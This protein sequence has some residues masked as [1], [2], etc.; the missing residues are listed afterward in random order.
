MKISKIKPREPSLKFF[1]EEDGKIEIVPQD[2]N[3][4]HRLAQFLL[5]RFVK[6]FF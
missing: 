3:G 2:I 6:A 4:I 1:L 5:N